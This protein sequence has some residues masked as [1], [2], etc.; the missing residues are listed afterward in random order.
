MCPQTFAEKMKNPPTTFWISLASFIFGIGLVVNQYFVYSEIKKA[1][2][3]WVAV[4]ASV[5][6]GLYR[7]EG[8]DETFFLDL[9]FKTKNGDLVS[10]KNHEVGKKL[11]RNITGVEYQLEEG[12]FEKVIEV[13][14]VDA[15]Y[16]PTYPKRCFVVGEIERKV[17]HFLFGILLILIAAFVTGR[18]IFRFLTKQKTQKKG[19]TT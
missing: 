3:S 4:S 12:K 1:T 8:D 9:T 6:G 19:G 10:V 13:D 11:F 2:N 5:E 18:G 7:R 15:F 16:D 14:T 17:H